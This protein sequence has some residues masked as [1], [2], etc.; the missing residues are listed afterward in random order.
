MLRESRDQN[1][2]T[3]DDFAAARATGL[4][5]SKK[6]ATGTTPN[7][8]RDAVLDSAHDAARG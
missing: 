3:L 1:A 8:F 6:S 4:G 5:I 7:A 2:I